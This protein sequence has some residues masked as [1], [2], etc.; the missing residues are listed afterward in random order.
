MGTQRKFFQKSDCDEVG[1]SRPPTEDTCKY[2]ERAADEAVRKVFS[3]MG[4][5]VD[6]PESVENFRNSLRFGKAM[7]QAASKGALAFVSALGAAVL[8][9]IFELITG[10]RVG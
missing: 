8:Y 3:I 10:R 9:L 7:H 4:V 1:C 6:D 5:N 2:S